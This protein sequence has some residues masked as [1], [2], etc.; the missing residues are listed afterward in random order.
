MS[1]GSMPLVLF[2]PFKGKYEEEAKEKKRKQ[3]LLK[4]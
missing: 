3:E 4:Q 1:Q 2:S